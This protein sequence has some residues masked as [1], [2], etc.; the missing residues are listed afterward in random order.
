MLRDSVSRRE[1]VFAGLS[2]QVGSFFSEQDRAY[3]LACLL[4]LF[5]AAENEPPT[6]SMNRVVFPQTLK[7]ATYKLI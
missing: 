5:D 2:W 4:A 6:L 7:T 1:L 3:S